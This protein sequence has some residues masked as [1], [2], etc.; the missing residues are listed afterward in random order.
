MFTRF[1]ENQFVSVDRDEGNAV[2]RIFNLSV[3]IIQIVEKQLYVSWTITI[4]L[5]LIDV[6]NAIFILPAWYY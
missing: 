4:V 6:G 2:K 5:N 1:V 3:D